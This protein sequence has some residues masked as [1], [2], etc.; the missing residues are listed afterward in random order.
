MDLF[1]SKK[2]A[3]LDEKVSLMHKDVMGLFA[4]LLELKYPNVYKAL[5]TNTGN[6]KRVDINTVTF[7]D[8][9]S[10]S[11]KAAEATL[12][13]KRTRKGKQATDAPVITAPAIMDTPNE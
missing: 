7:Q 6:I 11:I 1:N 10:M 2:I 9:K 5:T 4:S 12:T 3:Q 8:G 13:P